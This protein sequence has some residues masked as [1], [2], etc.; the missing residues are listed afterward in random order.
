MSL[1]RDDLRRLDNLHG[2]SC[3]APWVG[4]LCTLSLA[5]C[6]MLWLSASWIMAPWH[7]GILSHVYPCLLVS[8]FM[9]SHILHVFCTSQISQLLIL[10]SMARSSLKTSSNYNAHMCSVLTMR[11][12]SIGYNIS[13]GFQFRSLFDHL[14]ILHSPE[15]VLKKRAI[16]K[17]TTPSCQKCRKCLKSGPPAVCSQG[18]ANCVRSSG[19]PGAPEISRC[20][21]SDL[22]FRFHILCALSVFSI[23]PK[24]GTKLLKAPT[25][26]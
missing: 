19:A 5:S 22:T 17:L 8:V 21:W 12:R 10:H 14:F 15:Q 2:P 6:D 7:H 13:P 18:H 26:V 3:A 25:Y 9:S 20:H 4:T 1:K 23:G 11:W 16:G 24:P